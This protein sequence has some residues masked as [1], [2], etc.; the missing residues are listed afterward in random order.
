MLRQKQQTKSDNFR[1]TRICSYHS[2]KK[3]TISRSFSLCL[4]SPDPI[5][6]SIN[7]LIHHRLI[8]YVYRGA[9]ITTSESIF[10]HPPL[11]GAGCACS[12]PVNTWRIDW[13]QTCTVAVVRTQPSH[14]PTRI[15]SCSFFQEICP[16]PPPLPHS[17]VDISNAKFFGPLRGLCV[18]SYEAVSDTSGY[19]LNVT[20]QTL[21]V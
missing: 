13:L 12:D 9:A 15:L 4:T 7:R 5:A 8:I 19:R 10:P 21:P 6:R 20:A 18:H 17:P 1:S 16:L 3:R 2:E 11:V 14:P